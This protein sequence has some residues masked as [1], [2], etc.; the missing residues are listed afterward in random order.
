MNL[1]VP[2]LDVA[3]GTRAA[4]LQTMVRLERPVT[5]RQLTAAA[6]TS[7]G[8]G[9]SVIEDLISAGL[10]IEMKAGRSSLVSLNREH[11]AAPSIIAL[12][13]LRGELIRRLRARLGEWP[14][15]IGAWLFGSVARG[16]ARPDSDIDVAIVVVDLDS[17]DL[18]QR[19]TQLQ[20]DVRT[21]TGN[22]LQIVEHSAES[23]QALKA[24]RNTLIE[25]I[26]TDGIALVADDVSLLERL[27]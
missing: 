3:S 1:S 18:H 24:A 19:L 10:V 2:L 21:W 15:L 13:G 6:G 14:N 16:E 8:H 26:R 20:S 27:R 17:P 5:R 11:L 7:A 25:Q 23:W 4:L 12:A 9:N 22:D